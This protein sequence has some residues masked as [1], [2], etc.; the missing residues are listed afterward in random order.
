MADLKDREQ[1]VLDFITDQIKKNGYPPTVRDIGAAL[2]IKSTSTVQ[3]S[4]N[5]L[6]EEGFIRKQAGKRRAFEVVAGGA[7]KP[8]VQSQ[9]RADVVDVPVVGRVAAGMPILAEQNIEGSFPMPAQFIGKGTNFMLT[10]HGDSM[11]EAGIM[12]GDYILVQE[13]KTANNGDIVVAM[14]DGEFESESTV[15]TFYKENGHIRLQPQNSSMDPIIVD[16][17]EIVGLVKGV[18]R[19]LN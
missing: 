4:M 10:V 18:F 13:Q 14:I 1:K 11:I 17:C 5:I 15:K 9:D 7:E 16:D 3:K 6:E 8:Q 2:G 12:D 19:Y